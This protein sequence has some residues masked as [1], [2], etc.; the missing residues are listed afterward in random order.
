MGF[1]RQRPRVR[2]AVVIGALAGA[3]AWGTGPVRA[4]NASQDLRDEAPDPRLAAT[5]HPPLPGHPSQYWFVPDGFVPSTGAPRGSEESAMAR[6][7][8]GVRLVASGDYAPALPLLNNSDLSGSPLGAYARYYTAVALAGLGRYAEAD[9]VL[10]QLAAKR[11]EGYLKEAVPLKLAEVA[12]AQQQPKRAVDTLQPLTDLQ[13]LNAPE[14]LWLQIG[15]AAERAGDADKALSA[16]RKVYYDYPLSTQSA[17]AQSGIER[18]APGRNA[19]ELFEREKE[20]AQKLFETHRWAQSRAAWDGLARTAQGDD[21]ELA[22]LR[23]AECDYYLDRYRQARDELK[24]YQKGIS[25]EAE[26]RFFYLT[27]TRALGDQSAYLELASRFLDEFPTSDW[28]EETLNNL[29]THY[30]VV[31]DDEHADVAFRELYERFP[32]SR[33]ADRAAWK[34]GWR[35]YRNGDFRTAAETFEDAAVRFPRAD[36]RP[37]WLYWAARARDQM[38]QAAE[39]N[40]RYRIVVADYENS[41]YGR[42][43]SK[44]LESRHEAAVEPTVSLVTTGAAPVYSIPTDA[45]IRQL[46]AV[47]LYD[48]ALREVQYAQHVWGDSPQLVATTAWIR[49]NRALGLRAQERF[50]DLRGA[51]TLM[52]RAYPQFMAAGG[53]E[54]PPEVLQIIFPIDYWR[55]IKKYSDQNGLDPYLM[56]ALIAQEST[57]T[58]EIRSSANAYGLLQLIP[59]TARTYARK[60]GLRYSQRLLTQPEANMRI[61]MKYFADLVD[62]FGSVYLALASYNG[63][64]VERWRAEKPNLAQDEFIDDIP[65]PETQNYVKRIL[66]TAEDYR[67]L[68]GGGLLDPDAGPEVVPVPAANHRATSSKRSSSAKGKSSGARKRPSVQ[69]TSSKKRRR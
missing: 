4:Q 19:P 54:L 40:A 59:S 35:E 48:D 24:P 36:Y 14:E 28:A 25:R 7:A 67:R 63:G 21:A 37:S 10:T 58:A 20:R 1:D 56:A 49:H 57:F 46:V 3:L 6:F 62:H 11:L 33:Y 69:R 65:Y 38:G 60:A 31:D 44:L 15:R 66:G 51:I 9:T 16:Y 45:L 26:A 13:K 17:D 29:A 5:A 18:L 68:Y 27:A 43:A 61:G 42:L 47:Q 2:F 53:E 8:G 12:L 64:K 32:K 23:I 41:Y 50:N 22:A 30:I 39:A 52:R 55:L 34:I